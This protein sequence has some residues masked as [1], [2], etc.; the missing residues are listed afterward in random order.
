MR[1]GKSNEHLTSLQ[2]QSSGFII[3]LKYQYD[4][5]GFNLERVSG[6]HTRSEAQKEESIAEIL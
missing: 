3:G 2:L 4:S 1:S 6:K 5:T